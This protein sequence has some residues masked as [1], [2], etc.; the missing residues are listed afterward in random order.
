MMI[1]HG[2]E[3]SDSLYAFKSLISQTRAIGKKRTTYWHYPEILDVQPVLIFT[4]GT[5]LTVDLL[6]R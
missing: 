5:T 2:K 6:T 1:R 3:Y 4:L